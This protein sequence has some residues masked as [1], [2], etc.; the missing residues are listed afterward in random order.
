MKLLTLNVD[1][2]ESSNFKAKMK[3]EYGKII[4]LSV[5]DN[6]VQLSNYYKHLQSLGCDLMKEIRKAEKEK[7]LIDEQTQ[8]HHSQHTLSSS[9]S[10]SNAAI[11]QLLISLAANT[12]N[13][14]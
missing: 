10:Q 1:Y 3:C 8:R 11:F 2:D 7:R 12:Q 6:K 5:Y 14:S 13:V 9:S 4:S